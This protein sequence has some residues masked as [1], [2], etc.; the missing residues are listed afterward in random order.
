MAQDA[1]VMDENAEGE[2]DVLLEDASDKEGPCLHT[3]QEVAS[4]GLLRRGT[5]FKAPVEAFH[6]ALSSSSMNPFAKKGGV[7][8]IYYVRLTSIVDGDV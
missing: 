7:G 2:E 6:V 4:Y 8:S 5:S 1:Y 3:A